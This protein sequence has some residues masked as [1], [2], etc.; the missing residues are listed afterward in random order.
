MFRPWA[1]FIYLNQYWVKHH[2]GY[3]D[4]GSEDS[5]R[6]GAFCLIIIIGKLSGL[7]KLKVSRTLS[8][9]KVIADWKHPGVAAVEA[10]VDPT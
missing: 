6:F 10:G 7:L 2:G 1:H 3:V 8:D 9:S 4:I 5:T